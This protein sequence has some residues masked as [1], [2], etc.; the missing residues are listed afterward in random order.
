[1]RDIVV[2]KQD[3]ARHEAKVCKLINQYFDVLLVHGDPNF[4]PLEE[5]FSRV[6]DL[7]CETHYTGY[8]VQ[9]QPEASVPV[10][11]KQPLILASIG[12]G[13][14]GH[15]LLYALLQAAPIL[16]KHLPHQI[17]IF[18]GPFMPEETFAEMQTL[19]QDCPRVKL[20]RFTPY[21]LSYMKQADLSISMSGYNTTMNILT[22]G[23]RAILL[24]FTGNDDQEQ[25]LRSQKLAKLGVVDVISSEELQGDRFAQKVIRSLQTQ[26][27]PAT[28]DF[29]GV[30]KTAT[31]LKDLIARSEAA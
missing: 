7:D 27:S 13:R 8:V 21:L 30:R 11:V 18:T 10:E 15:E 25:T 4:Q 28:L 26:P 31:L 22:T 23:V 3:L 19:A 16:A 17:Q 29:D 24:P 14:F 1:L 12:G 9:P 2:T 20:E 6:Q 5:T